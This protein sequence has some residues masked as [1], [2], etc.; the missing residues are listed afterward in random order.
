M[1]T[2]RAAPARP[3]A[4]G[5][6]LRAALKHGALIAAANWPVVVVEFAIESLFKFALAV[7]VVGG[8]L[9]V[10]VLVGDD[11]RTFFGRGRARG[12]RSRVGVLW[13]ARRSRSR[14]SSAPSRSSRSAAA[15]VMFV[16]KGGTLAVLVASERSAGDVEQQPVHLD[17]LRRAYASRSARVI[18]AARA[19]GRRAAW[20][21]L[22]LSVAYVVI[23]VGVHPGARGRLRVH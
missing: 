5:L 11:V 2:R 3:H 16:V 13:A 19:F 8:A 15:L 18:E 17:A 1:G 14:P 9:M 7:P 4:H 22:G 20:L 23:G 12:R 10:A 21:A 6:P